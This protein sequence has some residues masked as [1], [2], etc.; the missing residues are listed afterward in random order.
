MRDTNT[1]RFFRE[2]ASRMYKENDLSDMVYA[3]CES[4]IEFR[5]HFLKFFFPNNNIEAESVTICREV[6]FNDGSRPDFVI[7]DKSGKAYFVEVKIWDCNHHFKQ[8]GETLTNVLSSKVNDLAYIANYEID[9]D[10]LPTDADKE[11]YDKL[12]GLNQIH[13]WKDF[14]NSLQTEAEG[15]W[16]CGEDVQGFLEYC[17]VVCPNEEDE[18]IGELPILEISRKVP[19]FYEKLEAFVSG[20]IINVK[21]REISLSRWPYGAFNKHKEWVGVFFGA[22]GLIEGEKVY[23]W[24]GVYLRA[25]AKTPQGL[26]VEFLNKAGW[27]APVFRKLN[28]TDYQWNECVSF[29]EDINET[30]RNVFTKAF[31]HIIDGCDPSAEAKTPEWLLNLRRIP[32]YVA[33]QVLGMLSLQDD[34]KIE[35]ITNSDCLDPKRWCGQSFEIVKKD[36][37]KEMLRKSG[38]VGVYLDGTKGGGGKLVCEFDG[39]NIDV[40]EILNVVR[41]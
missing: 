5:R 7:R 36:N 4:N 26:C 25:D 9:R 14:I 15:S 22:D 27:G 21:D 23:G 12:S 2:L 32:L 28:R 30:V 38:W 11:V 29:E 35:L 3:L 18:S 41:A 19:D 39:K 13:K 40:D 20:Q 34:E 37:G 1:I 6:S 10:G 24:I 33:Q 16:A 31:E 8:Y 17:K